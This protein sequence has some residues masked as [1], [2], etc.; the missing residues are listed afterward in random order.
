MGTSSD[1]SGLVVPTIPFET[2][3][4]F[5]FRNSFWV[6]C[7]KEVWSGDLKCFYYLH[8]PGMTHCSSVWGAHIDKPWAQIASPGFTHILEKDGT[9]A[10]NS[11]KIWTVV[12]GLK[13]AG[14]DTVGIINSWKENSRGKW[15]FLCFLRSLSITLSETEKEMT[16]TLWLNGGGLE[17]PWVTNIT[18]L[19]ENWPVPF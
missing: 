19:H 13:E 6:L 7:W 2:F 11:Y 8:F 10:K 9:W 18:A 1:H 15:A 16:M 12:I 14:C 4:K 17:K 5:K 3:M